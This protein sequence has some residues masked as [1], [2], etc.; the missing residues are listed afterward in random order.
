MLENRLFNTKIICI[1]IHVE[2][3]IKNLKKKYFNTV[4]SVSNELHH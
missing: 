1:Y 4:P 3:F 2:K